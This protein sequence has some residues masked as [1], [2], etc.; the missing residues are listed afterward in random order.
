MRKRFEQQLQLGTVPIS[1]YKVKLKSR[2]ELP[3]VLAAL[4]YVFVNS[5]I[6]TKIFDLLEEKIISGKAKTGRPGMNLWEIFV[7]ST[8][9]LCL[10]VNYDFLL[11]LANEHIALRSILGVQTTD[12]SPGKEYK[13]QTIVDNVRLLDEQTLDQINELIVK[14]GHSLLK[15]RRDPR[16]RKDRISN[17]GR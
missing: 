16:G 7:L 3:P 17:K 1:E 13:Y 2:H 5:Q 12:F 6:N 14:S 11:D 10:D 8:V 4:Q 15:K 9:R